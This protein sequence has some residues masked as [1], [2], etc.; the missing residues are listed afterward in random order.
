ME[1]ETDQAQPSPNVNCCHCQRWS[2]GGPDPWL[3]SVWTLKSSHKVLIFR[4][5]SLYAMVRRRRQSIKK[6]I[7]F[8]LPGFPL[9]AWYIVG[10]RRPKTLGI[11]EH[12]YSNVE[13]GAVHEKREILHD[14]S[15]L[16]EGDLRSNMSLVREGNW[17]PG[18]S[19]QV[20]IYLFHDDKNRI[21]SQYR[22]ISRKYNT[23][24]YYGMPID[25]I[26]EN[27]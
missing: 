2:Y 19:L 18:L 7:Q 15:P 17:E 26:A 22:G 23:L 9:E 5:T 25:L 21:Q 20:V 24:A 10:N 12:G 1:H 27:T 16:R 13:I 6:A 3:R 14:D 8:H 4:Y 11:P